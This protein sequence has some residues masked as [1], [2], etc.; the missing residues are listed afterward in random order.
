MY[1][2]FKLADGFSFIASVAP[3]NLSLTQVYSYYLEAGY[4]IS[5]TEMSITHIPLNT[6]K[7]LKKK[8]G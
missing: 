5:C 4:N 8:C 2:P 1:V 3:F 7:V 6:L